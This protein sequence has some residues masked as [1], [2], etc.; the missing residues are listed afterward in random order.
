MSSLPSTSPPHTIPLEPVPLTAPQ[1]RWLTYRQ[2]TILTIAAILLFYAS[3]LIANPLLGT[4]GSAAVFKDKNLTPSFMH[5]FGTD[6]LGRDML[7]RTVQ[8][9]A[10]SVTVGLLAASISAVIGAVLGT[11][12]AIVGG[13]I[14]VAITWLIDALFSVPH[15]VLLILISFAVG[16]GVRGVIIAVAFT[17]E[18]LLAFQRRSV[19]P[20]L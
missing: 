14:D 2:Q 7:V 12:S 9:L 19:K 20:P 17:H 13:K 3:L 1:T 5:V 6:W 11:L 4:I 15:L 18:L 10:L 8:G 16:G